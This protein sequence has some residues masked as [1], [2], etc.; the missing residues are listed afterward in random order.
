[1]HRVWGVPAYGADPLRWLDAALRIYRDAAMDVL[2]PTQ[3]QVA[4]LSACPSPLRDAGVR[5]AVPPFAALAQVQDK[6]S[7]NGTLAALGLPQP[8]GTVLATPDEVTGWDRFPVF[9]KLPIATASTGVRRITGRQQLSGFAAG[10][11]AAGAFGDGGILAQPPGR[12]GVATHQLLIA[13]L[14][15]A[16][17]A[18]RRGPVLAELLAAARRRG[19]YRDSTEELTPLRGDLR[20]V[21]PLALAGVATAIRPASWHWFVADSVRNYALAPAGWRQLL[22]TREPG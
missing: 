3:E 5:T 9:M 6:I 13:V 11:E 15:A 1:M 19:A 8:E 12:A 18:G 16:Q 17:Q 2:F 14:G 7:A 4:V 10:A 21:T 22:A 20:A